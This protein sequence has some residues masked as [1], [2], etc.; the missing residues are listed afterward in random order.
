L[1]VLAIFITSCRDLIK[2]EMHLKVK[3]SSMCSPG[4]DLIRRVTIR[5]YNM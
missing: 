2:V 1:L 4:S 5:I 3:L